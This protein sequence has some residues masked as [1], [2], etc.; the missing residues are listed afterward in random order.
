MSNVP[1]SAN[2]GTKRNISK[3]LNEKNIF[4]FS[5]V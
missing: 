5:D 4:G 3:C 2:D 1:K